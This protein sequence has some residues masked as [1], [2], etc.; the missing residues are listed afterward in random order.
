VNPTLITAV[1]SL[2][3]CPK[4]KQPIAPPG[5]IGRQELVCRR[6]GKLEA[7]ITMRAFAGADKGER[8]ELVTDESDASCFYHP[9]SKAHSACDACG[10]FICALCDV[11]M[12]NLTLCPNCVATG[13]KQGTL[14][15]GDHEETLWDQVCL[16]LAIISFLVFPIAPLFL[17]TI[18]IIAIRQSRSGRKPLVPVSRVRYV[19][20]FLICGLISA[21]ACLFW[22]SL[23]GMFVEGN[24]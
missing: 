11:P 4:C 23:F 13:R 1:D 18:L 6:C 15:R 7:L 16:T 8:A 20:A 24:L 5:Q 17:I 2:A 19:M 9:Q 10:R 14:L 21:G 12:G 22:F 3:A